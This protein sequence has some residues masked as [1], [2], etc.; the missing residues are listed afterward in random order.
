MKYFLDTVET[1]ENGVGFSHYDLLHISWLIFFLVIVVLNCHY[2]KKA[3]TKV[4][5]QWRKIVSLLIVAD[6]IFKM[7][8]LALGG[9]YTLDYLPL[10]LCSINIFFIA[11]HAWVKPVKVLESF[12]YAACIPGALAALLFPSWSSLPFANFMH[13]HSFTVHILLAMY[14][15]VLTYAKEIHPKVKDVPMCVGFLLV[16]AVPIYL[17]NLLLDTNFMFLMRADAG[18]PLALFEPMFGSHVWGFP[19]IITV[20]MIVMYF[21]WYLAEKR[22]EKN[23]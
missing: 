20:L 13:L 14:P 3:D 19:I 22:K 4:R 18:N 23:A 1:I 12:L 6:E 7:T 2:Y 5:S 15:I 16:L 11:Y 8:M 10:H 21:P 17:I 9:N